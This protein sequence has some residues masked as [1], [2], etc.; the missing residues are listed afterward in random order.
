MIKTRFSINGNVVKS[1]SLQSFSILFEAEKNER[2]KR[3][4]KRFENV[5][6][7]YRKLKKNAIKFL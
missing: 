3:V 1:L 2:P 7:S 5:E 6:F 4:D